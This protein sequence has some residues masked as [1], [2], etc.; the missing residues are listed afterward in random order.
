MKKRIFGL[1]LALCLVV[2][3]FAGCSLYGKDS[4]K[5]SDAVAIRVGDEVITREELQNAYTTYYNYGYG[6]MYDQDQLM[7]F[8]VRNLVNQKVALI[9]AKQTVKIT[10]EDFDDIL[11]SIEE[12]LVEA[13]DER[14]TAIYE[15]AGEELPERLCS[16]TN[17]GVESHK[18]EDAEESEPYAPFES[19]V[20]TPITDLGVQISDE[21]RAQKVAEF[22]AKIKTECQEIPTRLNAFNEY[23]AELVQVDAIEGK[24]TEK[25]SAFQAKIDEMIE[26]YEEQKYVEKL[27]E[28]VESGIEI[29][30]EEVLKKYNE[31]LDIE[32]QTYA[33]GTFSD[34]YEDAESKSMFLYYGYENV[35]EDGNDAENG[36]LRVQHLL[37]Q[38]SDEVKAELAKLVGYGISEKEYRY[39]IGQQWLKKGGTKDDAPVYAWFPE[40]DAEK[41]EAAAYLSLEEWESY[42]AI[43]ET[44]INNLE[45][46]Y[47][48]PETGK[49]VTDKD[50]NELTKTY[51]EVMAEIQAVAAWA[52][53][54]G[55]TD[56]QLRARQAQE[57]RKLMFVYGSDTG[58]FRVGY[59]TEIM[60]YSLP[61]DMTK[62]SNDIGNNVNGFVG[63]FVVGAYEL[64][65]TGKLIGDK[66]VMT[67]LGAH[68]ML[69]L[70][71]TK[72]GA[73]CEASIQAM[74]DTLLSISYG[75]SV[76]EYVYSQILTEKKENAY[77]DFLIAKKE[78]MKGKI[79]YNFVSYDKVFN[80]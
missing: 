26:Y 64:A 32:I 23:L 40:T 30:D 44:Y 43:R 1:L 76:Y 12:S 39:H 48:D 50:G 9:A 42:V 4:K 35:D 29:S 57:F 58:M 15:K 31:L 33:G 21:E 36:Y 7:D 34:S 5:V 47:L 18:H 10:V 74:K 51:A 16:D 79:E 20:V 60:G 27:Q 25:N 75:E 78:E 66:A 37:I 77:N 19:V 71:S 80:D 14:E 41:N 59:T 63:E 22:V 8:V 17:C 6:Y 72:T 56:A 3:A 49:K 45:T 54:S 2:P 24:T 13:I 55:E 67:D 68:V 46:T 61:A 38:F 62:F 69:N 70:G 65:T 11:A 73:V 28:Y 53:Q 52:K